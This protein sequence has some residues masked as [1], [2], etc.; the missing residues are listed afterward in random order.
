MFRDSDIFL[1]LEDG[2]DRREMV[3]SLDESHEHLSGSLDGQFLLLRL[4]IR[5]L[6]LFPLALDL[7]AQFH[8]RFH[9]F[10]IG[11]QFRRHREQFRLALEEINRTPEYPL[12]YRSA[13]YLVLNSGVLHDKFDLFGHLVQDLAPR[14]LLRQLAVNFTP[15][16]LPVTWK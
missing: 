3:A 5:G 7:L 11:V 15:R 14:L 4:F 9:R 10:K 1:V 12:E 8:A 2:L 6:P 16:K 13:N